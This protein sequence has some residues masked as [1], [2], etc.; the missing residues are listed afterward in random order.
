MKMLGN[1]SRQM[2]AIECCLA[3]LVCVVIPLPH[4]PLMA[5]EVLLLPPL[6]SRSSNRR[7]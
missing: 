2:K 3:Q 5:S 4:L 1:E 6:P 7:G